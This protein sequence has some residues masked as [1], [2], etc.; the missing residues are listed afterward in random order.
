LFG[1][2]IQNGFIHLPTEALGLALSTRVRRPTV[3]RRIKQGSDRLSAGE[4][5]NVSSEIADAH[6]AQGGRKI[7]KTL[8]AY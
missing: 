3:D 4:D 8:E 1:A 5:A 7:T 2:V 6:G